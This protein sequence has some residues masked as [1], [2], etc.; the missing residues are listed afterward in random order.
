MK[1]PEKPFNE[2]DPLFD[3]HAMWVVDNPQYVLHR[4]L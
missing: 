4:V 2:V 3:D 1:V